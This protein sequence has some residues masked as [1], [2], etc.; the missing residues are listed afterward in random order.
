MTEFKVLLCRGGFY[1]VLDSTDL[2]IV[3][4]AAGYTT[5]LTQ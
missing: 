1:H 4:S 2:N 5:S 3:Q